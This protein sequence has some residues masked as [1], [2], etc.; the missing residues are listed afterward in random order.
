M[1]SE[2]L[3]DLC[4]N[5]IKAKKHIATEGLVWLVRFVETR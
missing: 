2:N 3:Q 1:D 5:E 4:R